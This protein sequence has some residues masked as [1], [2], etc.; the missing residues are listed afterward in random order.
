[1]L[2][3]LALIR[4]KAPLIHNITNFVAMNPTANALLAI[5]ASPVMAQAIE[6]VGQMVAI[7]SSLV[8]NI[9]TVSVPWMESM[10]K[11]G[12]AALLKKIPIVFD[13]VG[14]GATDFR[15]IACNKIIET[16]SPN[17]IRG[18]GSE[19]TALNNDDDNNTKGVESTI[20]SDEA[21]NAAKALAIK[22]KA[23]IVVTGATDYITDGNTV[24]TSSYG[25]SIMTQIGRA[26]V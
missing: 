17:V 8:L 11:A 15:T 5:G 1:M 25:N 19:I 20:T 18:N 21:L 12:E 14:A 2:S 4:A 13:P 24:N 7:S 23:I 10:I 6:E 3:D 9:G 16:C 22:T 26:H